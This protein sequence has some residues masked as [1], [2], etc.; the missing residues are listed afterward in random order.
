[1]SQL[2]ESQNDINS[3]YISR[4][5]SI[6]CLGYCISLAVAW[7]NRGYMPQKYETMYMLNGTY[8]F[9]YIFVTGN[10]KQMTASVS[11]LQE[12]LGPL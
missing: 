11:G 12:V 7:L 9:K 4:E 1:M 2:R 8:I 5:T 3:H 6:L 10:D